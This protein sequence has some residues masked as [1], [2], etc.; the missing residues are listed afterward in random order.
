MKAGIHHAAM[1]ASRGAVVP[2]RSR[3]GDA[4]APLGGADARSHTAILGSAD[5]DGSAMI[6]SM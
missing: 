2:Q 6:D 4:E 5:T 3:Q 1:A